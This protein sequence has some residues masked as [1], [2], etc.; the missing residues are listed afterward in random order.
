MAQRMSKLFLHLLGTPQITLDEQPLTEILPLKGQAILAYLA[1]T[2]QPQTRLWLASL[3]WPDVEDSRALKNLRDILPALRTMVGEHLLITR[4]T[5]MFNGERPYFLD[6]EALQTRLQLEGQ[7]LEQRR[8]VID[9]Y[10]GEFLAGFSVPQAGPFEEWQIMWR[11]RLHELAL[12]QMDLLVEQAIQQQKWEMGLELTQRLLELEPWR[13]SAHYQRM[14]LFASTNNRSAAL[15]Q[16]ELCRQTLD[17]EF[18]IEPMP[19]TQLLYE[20]IVSGEIGRSTSSTAVAVPRLHNIPRSLTP[21]FGRQKELA[22]TVQ[23]LCNPDYPLVTIMGEGGIGK[24]RLAIAAAQQISADFKDG[25][26]FVPLSSVE[27]TSEPQMAADHLVSAID[28]ALGLT[29]PPGILSPFAYVQNQ[30][31]RRHMLLILDNFEHLIAGRAVVLD[32][33]TACPN[34]T[35]LVTSRERLNAQAEAVI[36][37]QGLPVPDDMAAVD[38]PALITMSSLQLFTER[39]SR[40]TPDFILDDN[41]L[42]DVV[43]ICQLVEGLPLGIELA[44][45]LTQYQSCAD[46]AQALTANYDA[47]A[48]SWHDLPSR[49]QSLQAVFEYSWQ[50]LSAEEALTL[51]QCSVFW[52]GFAATAVQ[53]ITG[54]PFA[55]LASLAQKSLLRPLGNGRFD[56]HELIRHFA[57]DKLAH[58]QTDDNPV[59]ARHCAYY[60]DFL[61]QRQDRLENETAVLREIQTDINNIRAAWQWAVLQPQPDALHTAVTGLSQFYRLVGF[62]REALDALAQAISSLEKAPPARPIQFL[63]GQ[64]YAEQS[65]FVGRIVNL[66]EALRLAQK[67]LTIGQDLNDTYLQTVGHVHIAAILFEEGS[68]L[69]SEEHSHLGLALAAGSDKLQR[70]QANSLRNLGRIATNRGAHD[71]AR[72]YYQQALT[73]VQKAGSRSDEAWLLNELGAVDWRQGEYESAQTYLHQGLA[74]VQAIGDRQT[75]ADI[76]KNLGIV[77]WFQRRSDQALPYYEQS[78]TIYKEIGDRT[79]ESSILNNMGLVAWDQTDYEQSARYYEQSLMIKHEIG[80]RSKAGITYGNLGIVARAQ[81]KYE[82]AIHYH[83]QSLAISQEVGDQLGNARTLNNLGVVAASLGQYEQAIAYYEQSLAIRQR[84]GDQ[85]GE[86]NTLGNLGIVAYAQG[87]YNQAER[88]QRQSLIIRQEIGDRAGECLALASLG[89]SQTRIGQFDLAAANLQAAIGLSRDLRNHNLLVE[90]LTMLADLLLAQDRPAAALETLA[91]VLDY[92]DA[93]GKFAGTEY[94]LNNHLICYRVLQ[95]T[96]SRRSRSILKMAYDQIQEQKSL[97]QNE[98]FRRSF[99]ENVPWRREI[100]VA[101]E[102]VMTA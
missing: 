84:I 26:W 24:T 43:R 7:S 52:G 51:A 67:T 75:E 98:D 82:Q 12:Q 1:V 61:R 102:K 11:E 100:I 69:K 91:E 25:V 95:A 58:L 6:V 14:L 46:I 68:I 49:H 34:L 4:Q 39:A 35:V 85:E 15:T 73:L 38:M 48:A 27:E 66:N 89:I 50:R 55:R 2:A 77:A 53:A 41:N 20:Q 10:K 96:A 62:Y 92:L 37:L 76:L 16:Y 81:G 57:A 32:L 47:L 18:G 80:E 74:I 30:L 79:G 83:E 86:G 90:A 5:L 36:R 22:Q 63:L 21:F 101:W 29:I 78:L 71:A 59:Q 28:N 23:L 33:L 93:G 65:Y 3:L 94:D 8:E 72:Q 44:A 88:Y 56:M 97:I 87:H 60:V 99:S 42:A 70:Q 40:T 45:V 19:Q 17:D 54:V 13:E 31:Y 9:L 64:L